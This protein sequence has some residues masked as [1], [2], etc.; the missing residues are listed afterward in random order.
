M[1]LYRRWLIWNVLSVGVC[2]YSTCPFLL[3]FLSFSFLFSSSYCDDFVADNV[4]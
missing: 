3:L 1:I 2:I 4:Q